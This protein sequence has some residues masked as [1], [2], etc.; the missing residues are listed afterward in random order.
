MNKIF[1]LS[2]ENFDLYKICKQVLSL[3]GHIQSMFEKPFIKCPCFE[4]MYVPI[5]LPVKAGSIPLRENCDKNL[6][7]KKNKIK[8]QIDYAPA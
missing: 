8:S 3:V 4:Y 6:R 5:R 1:G 2:L 7:T